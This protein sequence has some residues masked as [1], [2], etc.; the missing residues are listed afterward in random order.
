MIRRFSLVVAAT[1]AV[2][3][4]LPP[5]ASFASTPGC[6]PDRHCYSVLDATGTAFY[7][8]Y[9]TWNRAA[10][11]AGSPSESNY[12]SINSEM[13]LIQS[14]SNNNHWVEVG[15]KD[16]YLMNVAGV[17]HRVFGEWCN[18][19]TDT[20][21]EHSFGAITTD[22]SITDEFQISRGSTTYSWQVYFD[23]ELWLTST[24]PGFWSSVHQELGG[25]VKSPAA[26]SGLFSMQ[27]RGLTI[28]GV[29]ANFATDVPGANNDT[30]AGSGLTVL[31]GDRP[32]ESAWKWRVP[33]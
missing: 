2:G 8:M 18:E 3:A 27:G 11:D 20:C 10:L 6:S 15:M 25:E 32:G 31:Y 5:P 13:W 4:C 30:A 16:G 33:E 22:P 17:G 23:G 14:A 1:L 19:D 21:Y 29:R 12:R 9:G 24:K 28:S 26:T 7:G